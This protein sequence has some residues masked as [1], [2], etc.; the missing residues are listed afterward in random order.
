MEAANE[1]LGIGQHR[2]VL[3]DDGKRD[4]LG[5][6]QVVALR[7]HQLR[8][9]PG[10]GGLLQLLMADSLGASPSRGPFHHHAQ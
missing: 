8:Y 5:P 6:G 7:R 4:G 3:F 1:S 2:N 10:G 9:R